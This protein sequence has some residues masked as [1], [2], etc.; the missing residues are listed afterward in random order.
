MTPRAEHLHDVRFP[1]ESEEYR[2]ARDE[3]LRAEKDV[4]DR[5]EK[6]AQQRRQL[7]LGGQVP[8]D[9]VFQEWDTRSGSRRAVRLSELFEDRK[10]TLFVYS[11]MFITGPDGNPIGSPCP[12]CTSI[13][14][15]VAGQAQHLTQR[16][17]L[18]VSAKAPIEHFRAHAYSRGWADIRMLSTG[19]NTFNQDYGAE[20]ERGRQWPIATVFVRRNS[21][22]Y[23]WWS[24]ELFWTA[25]RD[26]E[27]SRHVDFMW[28]YWNILDCTPEGRPQENAPRLNYQ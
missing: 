19:Q 10:D 1:G 12:N 15:A 28:P 25:H 2:Q 9:Y 3:L 7:P 18:V 5:T 13:V 6:L 4:R 24:S 8:S 27:E 16:I 17:N 22:I 20:D 23:H 11:F 14:D 26:G 21:Q